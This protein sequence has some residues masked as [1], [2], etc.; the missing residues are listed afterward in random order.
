M[1]PI[2]L[3]EKWFSKEKKLNNLKLPAACCLSSIGLDG[4]PNARFV[5]LKEISNEYF[6]ITGSLG[7]RKGEE[8][9]NSPKAALS[10]WWTATER[11]VRIQGDV[12]KI[13]K[14]E[15]QIY[16]DKRNRDSKIVSASFKQGKTINSIETVQKQFEEQKEKFNNKDIEV[17]DN[18]S[19]IY[20]KPIRIEFMEFRESRLHERTLYKLADNDWRISI[21]QP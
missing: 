12:I 13:P 6:V 2:L 8:I 9:E 17:P 4:Y 7:S 10:F 5:S 16:F 21:L 1:N 11:Q 18:W 3:F 19:G 15:A 14:A 20:I